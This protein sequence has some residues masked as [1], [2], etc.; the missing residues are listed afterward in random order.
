MFSR[1]IATG[2][3]SL[4]LLAGSVATAAADEPNCTAA[5]L[6][7]VMAGVSA[8]TSAYLF[9]HPD[10]NA[11]FTS[12]KGQPKDQIRD[13]VRTYLDGNPQVRDELQGIRQPSVDFRN[14][15]G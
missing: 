7:G 8:S 14:R 10:V 9:T 2:A 1:V 13:Q 12:L 6:A 11:F 3:I 15:C 5:D 4:S